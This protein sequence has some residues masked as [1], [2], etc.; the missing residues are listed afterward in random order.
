VKWIY[1]SILNLSYHNNN[2]SWKICCMLP[3]NSFVIKFKMKLHVDFA[4]IRS[5]CSHFCAEFSINFHTSHKVWN[6]LL[7]VMQTNNQSIIKYLCLCVFMHI[8]VVETRRDEFYWFPIQFRSISG[9]ADEN[10]NNCFLFLSCNCY[11]VVKHKIKIDIKQINVLPWM[12]N[13]CFWLNQFFLIMLKHPP[14][15]YAPR[16]RYSW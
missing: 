3:H 9:R 15:I 14:L 12:N 10:G 6:L 8:W 16:K 5:T 1:D 2:D 7:F 13:G 11:Y 4:A